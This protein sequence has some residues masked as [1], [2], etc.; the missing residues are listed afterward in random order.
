MP[1]YYITTPVLYGAVSVVLPATG[2]QKMRRIK[3]TFFTGN[4]KPQRTGAPKKRA[5]EFIPGLLAPLEIMG[6]SVKE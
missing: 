6:E 3:F 2:T 4:T 5:L 1:R